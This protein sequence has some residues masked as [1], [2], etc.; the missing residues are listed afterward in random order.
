MGHVQHDPVAITRTA[1]PVI[2]AGRPPCDM[3][4]DCYFWG[5]QEPWPTSRPGPA[6]RPPHPGQARSRLRSTPLAGIGT[7]HRRSRLSRPPAARHTW[8]PRPHQG[9]GRIPAPGGAPAVSRLRL[10]PTP[11]RSPGSQPRQR[12]PP[13]DRRAPR[14]RRGPCVSG[15]HLA[16]PG[17]NPAVSGDSGPGPGRPVSGARARHRGIRGRTPNLRADRHPWRPPWP[18]PQRTS[19]ANRPCARKETARCTMTRQFCPC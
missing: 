18:R 16:S 14:H 10:L 1:G 11:A 3:V 5:T 19:A 2:G 12:R 6:R 4:S 17:V 9:P 15:P 13:P 8:R 7:P